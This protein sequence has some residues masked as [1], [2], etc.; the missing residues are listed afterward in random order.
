[1]TSQAQN[2]LQA[3]PQIGTDT[4]TISGVFNSDIAGPADWAKMYRSLAIQVVPACSPTERKNWKQPRLP[5]KAMQD[6]LVS[7][8]IFDGWYGPQG[9]DHARVNMGIVTGTASS[10]VFIL[11]LDIHKSADAKIWWHALLEL[12][13]SGLEIETPTQTTGGGGIQLLFR[14]PG[15]WT[16]PT[17]RTPLGVDLRGKG[18]FAVLPPSLHS[19]GQHYAWSEGFAPW[20]VQIATAPEWLCSEIDKLVARESS[21][22]PRASNDNTSLPLSNNDNSVSPPQP[23]SDFNG[24]GMRIN[25]REAYMTDVVWAAVVNLRRECPIQPIGKPADDAMMC[26][27]ETYELSTITRL[28][29]DGSNRER[30][31]RENRGL[32]LFREKWQRAI[33]QWDG[34]VAQAAQTPAR[35]NVGA[36]SIVPQIVPGADPRRPLLGSAAALRTRKFEPIR[37]IVDGF[38]IEGLTILAGRPKLGKSWMMLDIGMAVA[39]GRYCLGSIKCEEGDVLYLALEDNE[40]RL[41]NRIKKLLG[42]LLGDWPERFKYA[43]EWPRADN[44]GLDYVREWLTSAEKPRLVVVDVLAMF[45]PP[46]ELSYRDDYAAIKGLQQIASDHGVA[47]VVVHHLRKGDTDNDPFDKVSGTLGLSG[48]ADTVLILDRNSD[49]ATLYGRGRD[50]EEI[51]KAIQFNANICRWT[52]LG[53][54]SEIRQTDERT[55]ILTPLLEADEPM[56]PADIA[57]AAGM[58][59]NNVRQLLYKMGKAGEVEKTKRGKYV[60]P[61]RQDLNPHNNDNKIT[62]VNSMGE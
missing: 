37:W 11:D 26:A 35:A 62:G 45:R 31:E 5:W 3:F 38:L 58:P 41:Q 14:A 18:G 59:S 44:G 61:K 20:E 10:G 19:S 54:A 9:T 28:A 46:A 55:S 42:S 6:Q 22:T 13:N 40:R 53:E 50:I 60:H 43:T 15:G 2:N 33:A 12:H 16:A 1:M 24:F 27:Y 29:G 39:M 23:T 32:S 21:T 34:K 57:V 49:G 8:E 48:A 36:P 7:E 56:S 52:V 25:K 47:V 4:Q 17:N 30:L 51:E